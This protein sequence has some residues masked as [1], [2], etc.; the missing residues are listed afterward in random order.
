MSNGF[1]PVP[2][3]G[4]PT[5]EQRAGALGV[6]RGA[7]L[8]EGDILFFLSSPHRI[9]HFRDYSHPAITGEE[10]WRIAYSGN[11][12]D[13]HCWGMTIEPQMRFWVA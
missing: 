3:N 2:V 6:K 1:I 10:T 11:P 13:E 8:R 12:D 7:D 9:T 5:C 4:R